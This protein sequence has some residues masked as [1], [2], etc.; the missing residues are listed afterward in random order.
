M[1]GPCICVCVCVCV[2]MCV[3]ISKE[4]VI[5]ILSLFCWDLNC[6]E[7]LGIIQFQVLP[8]IGC[9]ITRVLVNFDDNLT[10]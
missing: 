10:H 2:C 3:Y 6:G 5:R 1:N 8:E 4:V 7:V 9:F